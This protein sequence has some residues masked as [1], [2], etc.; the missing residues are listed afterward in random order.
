MAAASGHRSKQE[1]TKIHTDLNLIKNED[2]DALTGVPYIENNCT[3]MTYVRSGNMF[4]KSVDSR[5]IDFMR[6][7][8]Q[9][10][11][12][13]TIIIAVILCPGL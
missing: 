10:K 1:I 4:V 11:Y 5:T 3:T 7:E 8:K 6:R 2:L 13:T 9:H 12:H